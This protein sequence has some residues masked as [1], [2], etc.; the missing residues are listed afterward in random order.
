MSL[1]WVGIHKFQLLVLPPRRS[2]GRCWSPR[3]WVAVSNNKSPILSS[4]LYIFHFGLVVV[5]ASSVVPAK[6]GGVLQRTMGGGW[7]LVAE[8]HGRRAG[9]CCI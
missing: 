7:G 3:P 8:D 1:K 9:L 4:P 2:T 6:D 5:R